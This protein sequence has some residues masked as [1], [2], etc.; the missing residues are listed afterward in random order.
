MKKYIN[1]LSRQNAGV[2]IINQWDEAGLLD[3]ISANY[4]INADYDSIDIFYV[5]Y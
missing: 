1:Y 2:Y 3:S 5:G 4:F